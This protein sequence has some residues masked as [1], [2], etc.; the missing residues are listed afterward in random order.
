[1]FSFIWKGKNSLNDFGLWIQKLPNRIR[2]EE[3]NQIV[4]IPGRS[5]SLIMTEGEDVYSSYEAE[6]VVTCLNTIPIDGVMEWLRGSSDLVLSND[7]DKAR[8]A[9]IVSEVSFARDGN[10]LLVGTIPFLFQPFRVSRFPEQTDRVT[11]T[12]ASGSIINPG[13]VASRPKI[14]IT[15]SG[16]NTITIGEMAMSF[17]GIDGTIV[18]DCDAEMITKDGALWTGSGTGSSGEF[19]RIPKGTNTITQ[20]GSMSIVIDP[21]WRWF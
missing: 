13:D 19:W 11:I 20:T 9:R 1:M 21:G 5:G 8:P 14:S 4:A 18:V 2:A 16:N 7:I 10:S 15:G 3:R 6:M 12:G 17:T